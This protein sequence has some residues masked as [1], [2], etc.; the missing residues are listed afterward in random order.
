MSNRTRVAAALGA[1][2]VGACGGAPRTPPARP[3]IDAA[4]I[5]VAPDGSG[6]FRTIQA[7]LDSIPPANATNRIILVRSGVYREKL[8]VNA[9]HVSLVGEDREGTRIEF[10]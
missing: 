10:A 5:T 3:T 4:E 1:L 9:S 8:F 7:A 6:D 2:A